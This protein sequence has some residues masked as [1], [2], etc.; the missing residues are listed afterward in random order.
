MW[1]SPP[2]PT[3]TLTFIVPSGPLYEGTSLTLTCNIA[4]PDTV[5]SE[6]VTVDVQWTPVGS[7]DRVM[8]S[9]VSSMRSPFISTLTL[10][11]LN[12]S[13]SG[14]YFCRATATSSFHYI[15]NSS[16]GRSSLVHLTVTGMYVPCMLTSSTVLDN[17]VCHS[18]LPAPDVTISFS[19]DST[20]GL[21]YS[22]HCSASVVAGL[23]VLP[24]LKIVFPNS[25]EITAVNSSSVD[26]VFPPLRTSDGGQ[27]TCTATV[28]I[29]LAG[30]T[31]WQSS[32]MEIIT[33]AS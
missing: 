6:D 12:M 16:Q 24:D 14:Q 20:A 13:D 22:L 10:S 19:G 15:T 26:Y 25:T 4:L 11:P 29:P 17:G 7:S 21:T 27:Y 30:I 28:N 31:D 2:V 3:P 33:V 1:V 9:A 18:A 23:V 5:D 8:T 32:A